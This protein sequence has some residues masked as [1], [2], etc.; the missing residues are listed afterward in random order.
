M[1]R[2]DFTY[3]VNVTFLLLQSEDDDA[4]FLVFINEQLVTRSCSVASAD[5]AVTP[6]LLQLC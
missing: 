2:R 6:R 3:Y 5:D 4:G 1:K